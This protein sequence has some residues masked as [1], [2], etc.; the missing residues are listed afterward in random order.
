MSTM[1]AFAFCQDTFFFVCY[2]LKE[3]DLSSARGKRNMCV[4]IV[5]LKVF[6]NEIGK[7]PRQI[8]QDNTI[9][10]TNTMNM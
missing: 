5:C 6:Q 9:Y 8:I 2:I 10:L 7:K 4:V 3:M 1:L